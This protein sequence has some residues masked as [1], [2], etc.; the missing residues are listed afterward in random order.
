MGRSLNQQDLCLTTEVL[1]SLLLTDK[2]LAHSGV[3]LVGRQFLEANP[4]LVWVVALHACQS[5]LRP[6]Q[7]PP[8]ETQTKSTERCG[9]ETE[10]QVRQEST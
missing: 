7:T 1:I 6:V 5:H 2:T 3:D 10:P 8:S 4:E 9:E